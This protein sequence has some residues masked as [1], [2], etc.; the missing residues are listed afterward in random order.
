[1]TYVYIYA[2]S[3]SQPR[4]C[5]AGRQENPNIRCKTQ[6]PLQVIPAPGAVDQHEAPSV[7]E[8]DDADCVRTGAHSVRLRDA[9]AYAINH[10]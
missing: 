7:T 4:A 6:Y 1:M 10:W 8:R 3:K 9:D 5:G 2:H